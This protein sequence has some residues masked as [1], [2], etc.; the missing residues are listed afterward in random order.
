MGK[1]RQ[2]LFSWAP[3]SLQMV[4]AAIKRCSFPGRKAMTDLDSILKSRDITLP[5][6]VC[7]VKATVFPVV[8]YGCESWAIK[9][10]KLWRT[11]AFELGCWRRLESPWDCKETKPVNPKGNQSWIFTGRTDAEAKTP[12]FWPSDSKSWL[13]WKRPWCWEGL[14]AGGKG[15][16]RRWAGWM[17]SPTRWVW[18]SS[19]SWWWTGKA[20]MLQS[21][22]SQR[23]RHNWA[24]ELKWA[25]LRWNAP[26]WLSGKESACQCGKHRRCKFGPWVGKIPW[27]R[28]CQPTPVFRPGKFHWKRSLVGYSPWGHK[29][30]DGIEHGEGQELLRWNTIVFENTFEDIWV[31][32]PIILSEK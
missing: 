27:R 21:I 16:N 4:T 23:V 15:D 24:T 9:K 11:D 12:I 8:M 1:E 30:S 7:L 31:C 5:T 32:H 10:A 26:P 3:K 29:T 28:K 22:R 2:T 25:E 17:A 20:G 6:K 19:G 18:A 13:D 14:K